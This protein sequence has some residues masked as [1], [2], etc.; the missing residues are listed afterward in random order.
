MAIYLDPAH[1]REGIGRTLMQWVLSSAQMRGWQR[2][3]LWVLKENTQARSFYESLGWR[4]DGRVKTDSIGTVEVT[5]VR[6]A[7]N[8]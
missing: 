5:E 3:T 1:W 2:L 8:L 4:I 7:L 6:Y